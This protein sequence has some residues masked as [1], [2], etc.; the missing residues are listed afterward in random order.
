MPTK[1]NIKER[2]E[3]RARLRE[4][5]KPGDTVYTVLRHVSAS[6]MSQ[7]LYPEADRPDYV[8]T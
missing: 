5:L 8:L 6:G 4:I 1:Q 2:D 3:A 7:V